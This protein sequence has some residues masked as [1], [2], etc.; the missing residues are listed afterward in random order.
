M[1]RARRTVKYVLAACLLALMV[2]LPLAMWRSAQRQE[3]VERVTA[4]NGGIQRKPNAAA[5]WLM[6]M[7]WSRDYRPIDKI[8]F[9]N[10]TLT[11]D[12][13]QV[14]SHL[15][16]VRELWFIRTSVTDDALQHLG[17]LTRLETLTFMQTEVTGAGLVAVEK[18]PKLRSLHLHMCPVGDDSIEPITR[19][20]GL[21]HLTLSGSISNAAVARLS[22]L[23]QLRSIGLGGTVTLDAFEDLPAFG[24]RELVNGQRPTTTIGLVDENATEAEVREVRQRMPNLSFEIPSLMRAKAQGVSAGLQGGGTE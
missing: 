14:L 12:D 10:A 19:M 7:G 20:T 16:D 22:S 15:D 13:L 21:H 4:L 17:T 6:S 9:I 11:P 18:L 24:R 5:E 23:D 2:G 1:K 8:T 3:A